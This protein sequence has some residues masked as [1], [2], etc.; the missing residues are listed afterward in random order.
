MDKRSKYFGLNV[1]DNNLAR[2]NRTG[3]TTFGHWVWTAEEDN[4]VRQFHPDFAKLKKL[5]RRRSMIAIKRRAIDL[6]LVR[7][8]HLWTANEV[9]KLR[10]RWRDL[11]KA[12][13]IAEFP[14]HTWIS[15]RCKGSKLGLR[16]RPWQPK[17]T[18]KQL[19]DQI[20][21]RAAYLHISL[22]DLDRICFSRTYFARSSQGHYSSGR[23]VLLTAVAALGGRVEIVWR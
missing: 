10:R 16:R 4:L 19:L 6:R 18:G 13:L 3:R 5:L 2:I 1:A 9:T 23:N 7:A 12:E 21:E 8:Q 17:P 22:L 15:I 20:R 11:S 14:R